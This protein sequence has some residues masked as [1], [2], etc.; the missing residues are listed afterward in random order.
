MFLLQLRILPSQGNLDDVAL[1]SSGKRINAFDLYEKAL[2]SYSIGQIMKAC[3]RVLKEEKWYPVPATIIDYIKADTP[4]YG[5]FEPSEQI[6][7]RETPDD[8][9][10]K[11]L[12]AMFHCRWM[13]ETDPARQLAL[14]EDCEPP[15]NKERLQKYITDH[16]HDDLD[17]M[18]ADR[19][20]PVEILKSMPGDTLAGKSRRK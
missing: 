5:K 1:D 20:T 12:V 14:V 11:R 15:G 3:D 19:G 4:F 17:A 2:G 13:Y 9:R 7:Y 16:W 10:R 8:L 6:E 18:A